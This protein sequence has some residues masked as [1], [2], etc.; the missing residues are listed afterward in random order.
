MATKRG[1]NAG[2]DYDGKAA[3]EEVQRLTYN[4]SANGCILP[5][6]ISGVCTH[7]WEAATYD[8]SRVTEVLHSMRPMLDEIIHGRKVLSR[9]ESDPKLC[10]KGHH[11]AQQRIQNQITEEQLAYLNRREHF[12]YHGWLYDLETLVTTGVMKVMK[13]RRTEANKEH[14]AYANRV[15]A[16]RIPGQAADF[17]AENGI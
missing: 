9:P 10:T 14:P 2:A 11:A 6:T 17:L 4:C 13:S 15:Q 12:T 3:T 16:A 1:F 8:W 5:G 7:H